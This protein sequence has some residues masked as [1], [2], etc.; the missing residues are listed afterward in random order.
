MKLGE[1]SGIALLAP[2]VRM[3]P[4]N[5]YCYFLNGLRQL[6]VTTRTASPATPI[7]S[8]ST[9]LQIQ[10]NQL[11]CQDGS[12]IIALMLWVTLPLENPLAC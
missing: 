5:Q 8:W 11:M 7:N 12:T 4:P 10:V 9:W 6:C 2:K 3:H 1:R